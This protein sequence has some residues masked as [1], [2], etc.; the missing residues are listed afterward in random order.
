[1]ARVIRF[2][3]SISG[4]V[5]HYILKYELDGTPITEASPELDLGNPPPDAD[6]KITIDLSTMGLDWDGVY[7][8]SIHAVDDAGNPSD[9]LEGDNIPFDF[10]APAAP[11]GLEWA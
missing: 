2:F 4:D 8:I 7:D 5:D 6:G 3:P 1:M 10:V 9:G 11:T